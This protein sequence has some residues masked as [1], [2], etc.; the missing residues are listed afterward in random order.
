MSSPRRRPMRRLGDLLP[1]AAAALGLE[2]ELRLARAMAAW[3][4]V[5]AE[6][7]PQGAG[8]SHL[9]GLRGDVLL[10]TA[11]SSAV[12]TEL[13]LRSAVLLAAIATAPGG[14]RARELRVAV[15]AA[16]ADRGAGPAV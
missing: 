7:I 16:R 8:A 4:R 10:V 15:R 9:I 3:D 11:T 1:E 12:A 2:E 13:Q 5:V 14:V 6:H